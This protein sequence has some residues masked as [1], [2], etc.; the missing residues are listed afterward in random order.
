[1]QR[2]FA[3]ATFS[4]L[5]NWICKYAK[6]H[7]VRVIYRERHYYFNYSY[8]N[9]CNIINGPLLEHSHASDRAAAATAAAIHANSFKINITQYMHGRHT[10]STRESPH[11][12]SFQY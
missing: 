1:M 4:N 5:F 6:C 9:Y 11:S 8:H 7:F 10:E 12:P 3:H 2:A